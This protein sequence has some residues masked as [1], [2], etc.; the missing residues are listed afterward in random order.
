MTDRPIY[1]Y[2]PL[3]TRP[4]QLNLN[5]PEELHDL[6]YNK[7]SVARLEELEF[8]PIEGLVRS[9]ALIEDSINREV[10]KGN[11]A[12]EKTLSLLFST[13]SR[14]LETLMP[15]AYNRVE[16]LQEKED[17]TQREPIRIIL[18]NGKNNDTD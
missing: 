1:R 2:D 9:L 3:A 11:R 5:L 14:M 6:I 17:N 10:A 18:D 7:T 4:R 15:Y 8:D 13:R 16:K 12:S